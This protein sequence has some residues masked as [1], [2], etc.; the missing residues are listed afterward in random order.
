MLGKLPSGRKN[1][2]RSF[3]LHFIH[4]SFWDMEMHSYLVD[5]ST[6][7]IP[8]QPRILPGQLLTPYRSSWKPCQLDGRDAELVHYFA[9]TAFS[10]LAIFNQDAAAF[11]DLLIQM[12]LSDGT[13]SSRAVLFA[14]L[15]VA[16]QHRDGL[17]CRAVQ[18]KISAISAL[19]KSAENG[20]L[21]TTEAAQHV[22]AGMLLCS[23][24]IHASSETGGQWLWYVR[25]V[26][27]IIEKSHL[28]TQINK[29]FVAELLDWV[30]Y[31]NVI[32]QFSILHWRYGPVES[33][34]AKQL[35][36]KGWEWILGPNRLQRT[37]RV[38][39]SHRILQFLSDIFN[40]L[41]QAFEQRD[42]MEKFVGRLNILEGRASTVVEISE[43][44]GKFSTQETTDATDMVKLYQTA[45]ML[46]LARVSESI[47]GELRNMK[48]LLDNAFA[49]LCR[50]R[51]CELQ[52]PLLVLGCEARTDEQRNMI[53]DLVWRTEKTT[54]VRSLDC[55]RRALRA[56]WIQEDLASD[57]DC[58]PK[59][60][61]RLSAI[62]SITRFIPS[63][64]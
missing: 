52:F 63:L 56:L 4:T 49:L 37:N 12:A 13:V 40:V 61:D 42:T 17:Q 15:A 5:L 35:D 39:P 54:Y 48:P 18:F 26:K 24:E 6:R 57:Q 33:M 20:T 45:A 59:Y 2:D 9:S 30:Y 34:F 8:N 29:S 60:M 23:F 50:M 55:L 10:S 47:S 31:H 25:G 41:F 3:K 43:R 28:D 64:V 11:R 1:W 14:L 32:A 38:R 44:Y 53:L 46:Y 21:S 19:A 36:L 62:I 27:D 22:T 51:T 7:K 16:S 58:V